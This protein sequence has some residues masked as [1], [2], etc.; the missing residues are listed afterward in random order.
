L[1]ASYVDTGCHWKNDG[2]HLIA[3]IDHHPYDCVLIVGLLIYL[4]YEVLPADTRYV[5]MKLPKMAH[6]SF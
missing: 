3:R 6:I 5:T 2:R 1:L 4:L